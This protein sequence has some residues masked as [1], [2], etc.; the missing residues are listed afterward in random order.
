M[1][2]LVT[3]IF[4]DQL[5]ERHQWTTLLIM[6]FKAEA[7]QEMACNPSLAKV[8]ALRM[9]ANGDWQHQW[10]HVERLEHTGLISGPLEAVLSNI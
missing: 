5:V 4:P 8:T 6:T 3:E 9:Q 2:W 7:I 1:D 10:Q